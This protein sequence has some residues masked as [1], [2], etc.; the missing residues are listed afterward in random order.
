[1]RYVPTDGKAIPRMKIRTKQS[2]EEDVRWTHFSIVIAAAVAVTIVGAVDARAEDAAP[3]VVA[4]VDGEAITT[5]DVNR[6]IAIAFPNRPIDPEV[7][8][9]V[10]ERTIEQLIRR[11]LVLRYLRSSKQIATQAEVDVA[12]ERLKK[13]LAQREESIDDY[14]RLRQ[15]DENGLRRSMTWQ[16]SWSRLLDKYLTDKNL[17]QFFEKHRRDFDGTEFRVAHIVFAVPASADDTMLDAVRRKANEVAAQLKAKEISFAEA[18]KRH[19][20]GATRDKGG[21]IGFISRQEPMPESFSR[22]AFGLAINE[23][24]DPV[25]TTIG[26]HLIRCSEIKPG[27]KQWTDVRAELESAVTEYLF[28]WAADQSRATANIERRGE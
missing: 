3:Q 6:E 22:A 4:T 20:S 19:S 27:K 11:Q 26:F 8:S 1:M 15:L 14:L 28:N 16:I 13:Q 18:A 23:I 25:Q 5:A 9:E 10:R 21:D 24:S 7:L 12:V 17:Q 2:P